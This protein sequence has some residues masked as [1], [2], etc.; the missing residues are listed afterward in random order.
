MVEF[1]ELEPMAKLQNEN[2]NKTKKNNSK[3]F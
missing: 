3:K 2:N 1:Q